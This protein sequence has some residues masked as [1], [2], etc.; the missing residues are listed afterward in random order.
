MCSSP[1]RSWSQESAGSVRTP[2]KVISLVREQFSLRM[3]R[4]RCSRCRRNLGWSCRSSRA[5]GRDG[6]LRGV[7][8]HLGADR[9]AVIFSVVVLGRTGGEKIFLLLSW[10]S[11]R[12]R[13]PMVLAT[14]TGRWRRTPSGRTRQQRELP[15]P[16]GRDHRHDDH[17]YM[18]LYRRLRSP[19]AASVRRV[20][21]ER[22]DT[23]GGSCSPPDPMSIIIATAATIGGSGALESR[24]SRQGAEPVAGASAETLFALGCSARPARRRSSRCRRPTASRKLSGWSVGSGGPGSALFGCSPAES[25]GAAVA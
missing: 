7:A 13:S 24:T 5:S 19:T 8:L 22:I 1:W 3:A 11:S 16:C 6:D 4:S 17:A 2:A 25:H 20:P 12:T 21:Q 9:S 14:R 23:I 15:V 18:Q 10:S